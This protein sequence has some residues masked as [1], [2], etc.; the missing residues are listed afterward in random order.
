MLC[1]YCTLPRLPGLLALPMVEGRVPLYN[2]DIFSGPFN[3]ILSPYPFNMIN[4]TLDGLH[5][6]LNDLCMTF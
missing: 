3:I 5:E 2:I 6:F 4:K 1:I